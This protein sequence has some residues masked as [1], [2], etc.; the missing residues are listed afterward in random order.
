MLGWLSVH[1]A[2]SLVH[3]VDTMD[4]QLVLSSVCCTVLSIRLSTP[5]CT[6]CV[7]FQQDFL[8]IMI[9]YSSVWILCL[10][11]H[12]LLYIKLESLIQRVIDFQL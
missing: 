1:G 4:R 12:N 6:P 11:V 2:D 5:V 10:Y 8:Q 9:Y 3:R 7:Q